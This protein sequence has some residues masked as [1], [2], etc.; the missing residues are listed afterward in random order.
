VDEKRMKK[1]LMQTSDKA[2]PNIYSICVKGLHDL[3]YS[4][5]NLV[6]RIDPPFLFPDLRL[7]NSGLVF[8]G[9]RKAGGGDLSPEDISVSKAGVVL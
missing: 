7:K 4:Y 1:G 8:P 5:L 9:E 2:H 6:A 3:I